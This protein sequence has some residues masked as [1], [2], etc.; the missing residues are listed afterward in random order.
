[1]QTSGLLD[2]IMLEWLFVC[3]QALQFIVTFHNEVESIT[4]KALQT[5]LLL[6]LEAFCQQGTVEESSRK[7]KVSLGNNKEPAV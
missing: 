2:V 5:L 6:I 1:M 4:H 3:E 7:E